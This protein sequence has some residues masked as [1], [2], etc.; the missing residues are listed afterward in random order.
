M[1]FEPRK[2]RGEIGLGTQGPTAAAGRRILSIALALVC[3]AGFAFGQFGR[4]RA[5][6]SPFKTDNYTF[7]GQTYQILV[8]NGQPMQVK[9]NNQIVVMVSNGTMIGYPGLDPHLVAAAEDALKAYEAANG[10]VPPGT[11]TGGAAAAAPAAGAAPTAAAFTV[12][13]VVSLLDA[14]LSDDIIL[15][16]IHSSGATFNLSTDD[17]IRLKKAK[18]SDAV[19]KAMMDAKPAATTPGPAGAT[20]QPAAATTTPSAA[21]ADSSPANSGTPAAAGA[22]TEPKKG[23]LLSLDRLWRFRRAERPD[24]DRQSGAAQHPR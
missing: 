15:A 5:G 10:I 23:G 19:I 9:L 1:P 14:G 6:K 11:P 20:A 16:K 24:G 13:D 4:S 7:N 21:T 17:L 8:M 22:S 12:N 3:C 2:R 18:A